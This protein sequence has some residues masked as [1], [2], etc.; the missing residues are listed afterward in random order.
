MVAGGEEEEEEEKEQAKPFILAAEGSGQNTC[1]TC[2]V[3][4]RIAN[5][6]PDR[7]WTTYLSV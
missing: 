4:S 5:I 1:N 6:L 7:S 3:P 2:A